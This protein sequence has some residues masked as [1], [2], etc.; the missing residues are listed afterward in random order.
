MF[1]IVLNSELLVIGHKKIKD[2][3]T[4]PP[5]VSAKVLFYNSEIST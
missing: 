1:S 4:K 3:K 2:P 5:I